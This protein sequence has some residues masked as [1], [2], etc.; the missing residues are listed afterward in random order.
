MVLGHI[1]AAAR[2]RNGRPG[3]IFCKPE[4]GLIEARDLLI[5]RNAIADVHQARHDLARYAKTE[6]ALDPRPHD[7][8]IGELA[9]WGPGLD[10]GDLD[11]TDALLLDRRFALAAGEESGDGQ[12][13][14][15]ACD[16]HACDDS[17]GC[18]GSRSVHGELRVTCGTTNSG[19]DRLRSGVRREEERRERALEPSMICIPDG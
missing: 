7:A 10:H 9:C 19:S 5:N 16:S 13:G 17:P 18:F 6:R 3:S 14:Y 11:R 1:A 2:R 4:I 8:G 15:Q 12:D